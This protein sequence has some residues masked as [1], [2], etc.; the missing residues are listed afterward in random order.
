MLLNCG[1]GEDSWESLGLQGDPTSPSSRKSVLNIHWKDWCWSWNSNTLVICFEELTHWK[2][3]MLGKIEGGKGRGWQ[4]M[5]WL[6]GIT[7]SM[8]M[9][10]SKLWELMMDRRPG[11]LRSMGSQRVGHDW[12]TELNWV[13]FDPA[14]FIFL[15]LSAN[16]AP[17]L[18]SLIECLCI[19]FLSISIDTTQASLILYL[20]FCDISLVYDPLSGF[21]PSAPCPVLSHSVKSDPLWPHE[22]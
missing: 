13:I 6:D 15:S 16:Q 9:R 8:D 1:V 18:L 14:L 7:N 2:R 20:H 5:R 19:H 10:L 11:M 3:P 4:R 21:F 12:M 22:L 17:N